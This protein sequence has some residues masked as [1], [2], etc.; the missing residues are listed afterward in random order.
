[1]RHVNQGVQAKINGVPLI[2]NC[3]AANDLFP[4]IFRR[5]IELNF[6]GGDI[7]GDAGLLLLR[8]ADRKLCLLERIAPMLPD[9]GALELVG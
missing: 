8:Q 1:M 9:D 3:T 5:K 2:P 7:T 4:G 6:N